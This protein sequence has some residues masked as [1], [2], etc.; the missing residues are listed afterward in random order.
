M[1]FILKQ[2]NNISN[3]EESP[4]PLYFAG[5]IRIGSGEDCDLVL[6][7]KK[8]LPFHCEIYHRV[9]EFRFVA[10]Q[11]AFV[12]INESAVLKWPAVLQDGD[13]LTIGVTNFQFNIIKPIPRRSWRASFASNLAIF[14]LCLLILFEIAVMVWLP[15]TLSKKRTWEL[16][17]AKQ[18]VI[19]QIDN[20]RNSTRGMSVKGQDEE[21][22]KNLLL[23]CEDSYAT[24]LRK[25]SNNM[26]REQIRT[27]H[28]NLYNL[29]IIV[30]QWPH[31]KK[32]YTHQATINPDIFINDL[33]SS[34][35]KQTKRYTIPGTIVA[36]PKLKN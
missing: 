9:N 18:Y 3:E 17:T 6:K 35:E 5:T 11:S 28:K 1:P 29:K 26:N 14:L 16:A 7:T 4:P 22:I 2:L 27:V 12:E 24:Y 20:L 13:I 23:S 33:C 32:S 19:R 10:A 8:I 25:Y 30:T 15:Y 21:S 31:Y 34:L 36:D